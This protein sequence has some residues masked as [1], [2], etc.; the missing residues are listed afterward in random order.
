MSNTEITNNIDRIAKYGD[1]LS[2]V[3]DVQYRNPRTFGGT[4]QGS[5]LG[6]SVHLEGISKDARFSAIGGI[7]TR[8]NQ[9]YRSDCCCITP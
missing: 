4:V 2:S 1:K 9:S 5:L 3:L 6:G 8:S 7:R